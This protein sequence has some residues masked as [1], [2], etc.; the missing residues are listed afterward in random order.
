VEAPDFVVDFPALWVVPAW[1]ERHCTIP[2]G[3]AKGEPFRLYDWQLWCT[4]NHYRVRPRAKV[5][6]KAPAF[7]YR[8]SQVVA[9]QKT[10]KGPWSA[11]IISAEA[12][13]PVVFAGWAAPG[14]VYR[15]RDHGCPCG[16]V[17]RYE[18]GEP[19]GRPWATPLIQLLASAE[20]QTDNVYRPLQAMARHDRMCGR[21]RVG[22]QFIRLPNDGRIDVV[23]SSAL[24]R[25]GN[26]ITFALQDES[27]L[28]TA[29]NK[30]IKVAET[31]RR[32]LAGM[33]GRSIETTNAP[34]PTV[35]STARRTMESKAKDVFRFHRI[36]PT[37]LDYDDPDDRREIHEYV[38]AGSA[39]V[40]DHDGLDAIEAEAVELMEKDPA[41]AERFYGNRLVAGSGAAFDLNRFKSLALP[42]REVPAGELIVVGVDGAQFRDALALI[43]T[44]V[45]TGHQWAL[46]IQERPVG[47]P[48]DYEHDFE[49]ADKAMQDAFDNWQVWRVYV[50]PQWIDGLLNT[51]Q[52][53]WGDR[54]VVPWL[55]HRIRPMCF[56]LAGYHAAIR[57]G[58][59]TND[60]DET[61]TAHIG[62]ATKRMTN[63]L[64]D[65]RRPM[66]LIEKPEERRKIDA[67]MAGALSWQARG[68]AV[69]LG[70][71]K[72][73][74]VVPRRI[75]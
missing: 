70:A 17:Y 71:K 5:G 18:E 38:Y 15:C 55:T 48:D 59:A 14:D 21:M 26:P 51:W 35:D 25:L 42:D 46:D 64:D 53:R 3:D 37:H 63:V 1:I 54:V 52:G 39:H 19:M 20:D 47:A 6:Q 41:Q 45:E 65:D 31:Q 23:T 11:T 61:F 24:A 66:W 27:Q 2:D 4:I 56:A 16:W 40:L 13:G 58:E 75:R 57:T 10:G 32:G 43:A 28:Y 69:A 49:R 34:D 73:Q 74:R 12:V 36:P 68:D 72:K 29:T 9:P 44:D 22:E 8:R 30:L 7:T 62:N 67:A 33:G 50:D 60:G